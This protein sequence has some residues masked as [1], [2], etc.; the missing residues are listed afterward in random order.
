MLAKP[1]WKTLLQHCVNRQAYAGCIGPL[2]PR[3]SDDL[4]DELFDE[5]RF[6]LCLNV[7]GRW[8]KFLV[9]RLCS[10]TDGAR[11]LAPT[12]PLSSSLSLPSEYPTYRRAIG[13][14]QSPCLRIFAGL[15]GCAAQDCPG[16]S[17][18]ND[19]WQISTY[20]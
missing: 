20:A 14:P 15:W 11:S 7:G 4:N 9:F 5:G 19:D 6:I 1:H 16:F 10:R 3:L 12:D 13:A 17:H 18:V 8:W 2:E